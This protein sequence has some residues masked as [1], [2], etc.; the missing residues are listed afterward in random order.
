MALEPVNHWQG[1]PLRGQCGPRSHGDHDGVALDQ[2]AV[3]E[4][5]QSP[6]T[7]GAAGKSGDASGSQPGA[8]LDGGIQHPARELR[9][10]DL[11]GGRCGAEALVN[12]R[13]ASEP[14][15]RREPAGRAQRAPGAG[16]HAQGLEPSITPFA[17]ERARQFGM[18]L[19][20]ASGERRKGRAVTP[21][22]GKKPT[23]LARRGARDAGPLDDHDI[24]LLQAGEIGD[25]RADHAPAT[26]Q[27]AHRRSLLC[28]GMPGPAANGRQPGA[29]SWQAAGTTGTPGGLRPR[30]PEL[31][32]VS[33]R[34]APHRRARSCPHRR[35]TPA[36]ARECRRRGGPGRAR[37]NPGS[38]PR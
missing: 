27:N 15:R 16:H 32:S 30:R 29:A 2:F 31:A 25:G 18:K 1:Q 23:G 8:P 4:D 6:A 7:I 11:G 24:G 3:H 38:S 21:V 14:F 34:H 5:A 37:S 28:R 22:E 20:A 13:V 9:R 35:S 17:V 33:P 10:M 36:R 12:D 26:D 19:E